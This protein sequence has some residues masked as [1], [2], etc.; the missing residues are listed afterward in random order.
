MQPTDDALRD[1]VVTVNLPG[2]IQLKAP[3]CDR[4]AARPDMLSR[5]DLRSI[6]ISLRSGASSSPALSAGN[7]SSS[8][9]S[10]SAGRAVR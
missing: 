7:P 8:A 5:N 6:A 9:P 1:L 2:G 10:S 3:S 4:T